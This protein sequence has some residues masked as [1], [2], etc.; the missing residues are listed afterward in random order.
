MHLLYLGLLAGCLLVSVPLEFALQ[1]RVL[2]RPRRWLGA[3]LPVAAA[4]VAW[5]CYAVRHR[6]WSYDDVHTLGLRLPEA[7]FARLPLEEVLFFLVVPT[8]A[9]LGY[10]AVRMVMFRRAGG[11]GPAGGQ[12]R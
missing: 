7:V 10:E 4:F 5:D 9:I 2:S 6:Q 1:L 12:R 3:V 11:A 8:A